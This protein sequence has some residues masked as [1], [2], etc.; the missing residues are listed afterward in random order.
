MA[1]GTNRRYE[2]V[3][4][5]V[6]GSGLPQTHTFTYAPTGLTTGYTDADGGRTTCSYDGA[7]QCLKQENP[8]GSATTT[9]YDSRGN[10]VTITHSGSTLAQDG[11]TWDPNGNPTRKQTL[12]GVTTWCQGQYVTPVDTRWLSPRIAPRRSRC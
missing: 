9:T 7:G 5:T 4:M 2:I 3:T 11:Y 8:N 12:T 1:Y 10:T 6:Q